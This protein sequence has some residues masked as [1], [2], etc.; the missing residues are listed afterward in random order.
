M[1][2]TYR[3]IINSLYIA[4]SWEDI[5]RYVNDLI[6]GID[7][8]YNK[9]QAVIKKIRNSHNS[10]SLIIEDLFNTINPQIE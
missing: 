8:L 3:E 4:T 1:Y 10:T 5:K 2:E 6:N 9:R 7:P